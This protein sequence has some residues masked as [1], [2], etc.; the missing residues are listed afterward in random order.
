MKLFCSSELETRL[1]TTALGCILSLR[2]FCAFL[3]LQLLELRS[4]AFGFREHLE[5]IEDIAR[6][7]AQE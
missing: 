2:M 3:K 6:F 1:V 7:R 5:K 4:E